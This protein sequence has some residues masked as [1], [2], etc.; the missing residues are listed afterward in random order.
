MEIKSGVIMA[1][2]KLEMRPV[3]ICADKVWKSFSKEL[4]IT[5]ALDGTHSPGSL[6]PFGYAL[7]FRSRYFTNVQIIKVIAALKAH[8]GPKYDVIFE[9]DH[10]HAEYDYILK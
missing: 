7:D 5:S 4:V 6:H 9:G 10:I 2:L 3:I 8:L 1:G